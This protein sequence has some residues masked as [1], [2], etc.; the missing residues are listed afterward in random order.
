MRAA[1]LAQTYE[2]LSQSG[3]GGVSIDEVARRSGVAKT[4]I[5]RHWP[6]RAA[7]LIE[8]CS[9]IGT[10][11]ETPDTGSL[12]GDLA[13]LAEGLAEQLRTARWA[14][15]LPSI[16]D[17]AEREPELAELHADLHAQLMAPFV[18]VV[19]R[20][21]AGGALTPGRE[22]ADVV[23]AIAGPLF[24][25]RWFSREPLDE[26]FVQQVVQDALSSA[27]TQRPSV[28]DPGKESTETQRA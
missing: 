13:E 11:P 2:L 28:S 16:V 5:C 14:A 7:L 26:A 10:A 6:S 24:Y 1:V 8:A 12:A 3:I 9:T 19:E 23:A 27:C 25:R 17:S 4:T 21:R 18:A 20:T 15:L 22:T